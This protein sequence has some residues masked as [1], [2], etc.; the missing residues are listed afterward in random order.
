MHIHFEARL[1]AVVGRQD[2][3][4]WGSTDFSLHSRSSSTTN[5][6]IHTSC[7]LERWP[8]VVCY[9]MN[10]FMN[11]WMNEWLVN[12]TVKTERIHVSIGYCVMAPEIGRVC[13]D[14]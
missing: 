3:I 14:V 8:I 10:C 13:D 12:E 9:I 6:R 5:P 1:F 2:R 7:V 11:E 4:L